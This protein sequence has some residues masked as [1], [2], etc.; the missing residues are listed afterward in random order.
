M[1]NAVRSLSILALAMFLTSALPANAQDNH[2]NEPGAV[3]VMTNNVGPQRNHFVSA[4]RRRLPARTSPL[5][6]RRPG[7]W[8]L[9]RSLGVP[10]FAH[11]E[12]GPLLVICREWRQRRSLRPFSGRLAT[13]AG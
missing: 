5:R 7:N 13:A 9:D 6:D 11:F 4:R 8:G 12:P 1:R 2:S 3:F 10:G